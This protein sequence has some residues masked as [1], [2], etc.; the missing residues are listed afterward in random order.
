MD[1][2]FT[3]PCGWLMLGIAAVLIVLGYFMVNKIVS[4]EV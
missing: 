2:L 3:D 1:G 4:I